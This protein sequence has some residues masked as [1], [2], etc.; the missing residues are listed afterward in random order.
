VL[1]I[2]EAE[3]FPGMEDGFLIMGI[4]SIDS[5]W[6]GEVENRTTVTATAEVRKGG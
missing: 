5:R 6:G 4:G 2:T 1:Y 3:E